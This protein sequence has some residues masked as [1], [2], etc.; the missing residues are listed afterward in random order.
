MRLFA[1]WGNSQAKGLVSK[2]IEGYLGGELKGPVL[3][4]R[5]E[6]VLYAMKVR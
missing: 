2:I 1:E 6:G 3:G 5:D 4:F